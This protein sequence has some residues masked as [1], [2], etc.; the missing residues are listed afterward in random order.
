MQAQVSYTRKQFLLCFCTLL[1]A[2]VFIM[3]DRKST[4][5][6]KLTVPNAPKKTVNERLEIEPLDLEKDFE[7]KDF[8]DTFPAATKKVIPPPPPPPPEP[9]VEEIFK[10]VEQMPVFQGCENMSDDKAKK[11]CSDSLLLAFIYGH[12]QY[13]AI[14]RAKDI[15]GTVIIQFVL[16]KN[17][18]IRD[19]RIIRDIGG[20]CGAE[21][22]RILRLLNDEEKWKPS[23]ARG[24]SVRV[25]YNLPVKFKL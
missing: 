8:S 5:K 25:Q 3:A 19:T 1:I 21:V 18:Q 15:E 10:V 12:L 20:Q 14:A 23:S 13:P 7:L 11:A 22:L 9:E 2:L 17:G 16:E 24:K 6:T 4:T